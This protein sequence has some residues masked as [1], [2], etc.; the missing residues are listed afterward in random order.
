MGL[1]NSY[2]FDWLTDMLAITVEK[3]G[4]ELEVRGKFAVDVAGTVMYN[5]G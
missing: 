4:G 1:E 2:F 3:V 5:D